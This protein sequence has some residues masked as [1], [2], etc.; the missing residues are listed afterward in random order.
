MVINDYQRNMQYKK[1][2]GPKN[3]FSILFR[4]EALGILHFPRYKNVSPPH[5]K[6]IV[7][8]SNYYIRVFWGFFY[9]EKNK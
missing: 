7:Y 8:Y 4:T 9:Y 1:K 5:N 3:L 2:L 6:I